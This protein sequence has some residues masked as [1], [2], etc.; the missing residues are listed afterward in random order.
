MDGAVAVAAAAG[1]ADAFAWAEPLEPGALVADRAGFTPLHRAAIGGDPVIIERLLARGPAEEGAEPPVTLAAKHG[2]A[3]AVELLWPGASPAARERAVA[4]AATLAC[5]TS[6]DAA[7]LP[8]LF[9]ALAKAGVEVVPESVRG[10]SPA[11]FRAFHEVR[12]EVEAARGGVKELDALVFGGEATSA[13]RWE[14]GATG[15]VS[16]A[17]AFWSPLGPWPRRLRSEALEGM[18]PGFDVVVLGL[19]PPEQSASRLEALKAFY[20]GTYV[21]RVKAP[22]AEL[23]CPVVFEQPLVS[24]T[25]AAKVASGTLTVS[26]LRAG[27]RRVCVATRVASTGELEG[28]ATAPLDVGERACADFDERVEAS[29][30]GGSCSVR[31]DGRTVTLRAK[32]A[33]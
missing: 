15:L 29:A 17:A 2:H 5:D 19:C 6:A 26:I 32:G 30:A 18:K 27:G 24:A 10:C 11:A 1:D 4:A 9:R 16:Q 25:K 12:R 33:R 23:G 28:L 14:R 3:R 31:C 13:E 20:P 21:R 22:A 8:P 7:A